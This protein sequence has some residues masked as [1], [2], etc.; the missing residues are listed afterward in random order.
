[1]KVAISGAHG[2][3]GWHT[4]LRLRA[5]YGVD[6]VMLGREEFAGRHILAGALDGV[7][8]IVHLAGVNRGDTDAEVEDGNIEIAD[9]LADG[10]AQRARAVHI[11]YANSVQ[12]QFDTPYGRGKARAGE[13]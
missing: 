13:K 2:F 11:V 1:M 4:A 6:P 10:L 3:L 7:D 9:R 12:S 8:T 5:V